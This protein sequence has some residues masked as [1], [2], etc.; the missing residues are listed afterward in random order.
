[1][2]TSKRL[3]F[4]CLW[5]EVPGRVFKTE[6]H[7]TYSIYKTSDRGNEMK[8]SWLQLSHYIQYQSD[9]NARGEHSDSCK[10]NCSVLQT[11]GCSVTSNTRCLNGKLLWML[12]HWQLRLPCRRAS[13]YWTPRTT[14]AFLEKNPSFYVFA[15]LFIVIGAVT[16]V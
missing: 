12:W 7:V 4:G 6:W 15:L 11:F 2:R 3:G 10:R 8:A 9:T 16:K 14:L 13:D 1:M 5:W